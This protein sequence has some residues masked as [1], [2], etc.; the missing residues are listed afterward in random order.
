M[1]TGVSGVEHSPRIAECRPLRIAE[2]RLGALGVRRIGGRISRRVVLG[3]LLNGNYHTTCELTTVSQK[4][5]GGVVERFASRLASI[6][7]CAS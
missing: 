5:R 4:L 6:I 3:Q 2:L 7:R 1:Q